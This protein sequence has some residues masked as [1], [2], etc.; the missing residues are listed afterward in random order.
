MKLLF[1]FVTL[2]SLILFTPQ[3]QPVARSIIARNLSEMSFC[4]MSVLVPHHLRS[5]HE[6]MPLQLM[7]LSMHML[8][9]CV[10]CLSMHVFISSCIYSPNGHIKFSAILEAYYKQITPMFHLFFSN[11][12]SYH[13][14]LFIWSIRCPVIFIRIK[15]KIN[16]HQLHQ[17]HGASAKGLIMALRSLSATWTS[18]RFL[19]RGILPFT[20]CSHLFCNEISEFRSKNKEQQHSSHLQSVMFDFIR[21]Y[22]VS[23]QKHNNIAPS[24]NSQKH[25]TS[26]Q[27]E[28]HTRWSI[29]HVAQMGLQ[30]IWLD[31]FVYF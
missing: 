5:S 30:A 18:R 21:K 23:K 4:I 9:G 31:I 29:R 28:K 10:F 2:I 27:W 20:V 7:L 13:H 25:T 8:E 14:A 15:G 17:S 6:R 11:I 24:K 16:A 22:L 3:S 19:H 1:L 26:K 12:A